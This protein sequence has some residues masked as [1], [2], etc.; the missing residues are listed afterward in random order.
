MSACRR[1]LHPQQSLPCVSPRTACR[2]PLT[3]IA[4]S[5]FLQ[6]AFACGPTPHRISHRRL[7]WLSPTFACGPTSRE[8]SSSSLLSR[9]P[10]CRPTPESIF[11]YL[12]HYPLAPHPHPVTP[13]ADQG[14]IACRVVGSAECNHLHPIPF[15]LSS[16]VP[17]FAMSQVTI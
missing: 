4:L 2:Q 12:P 16:S 7:H 17:P 9:A 8:A 15:L 3:R 14:S 13:H 11:L 6:W 1:A 10:A 5:V